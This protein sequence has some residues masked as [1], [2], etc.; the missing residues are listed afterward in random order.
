MDREDRTPIKAN[1]TPR[2]GRISQD[3][4]EVRQWAMQGRAMW[5]VPIRVFERTLACGGVNTSVWVAVIWP[6]GSTAPKAK[7]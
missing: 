7:S 4:D 6:K 3:A 5:G 1:T 2:I